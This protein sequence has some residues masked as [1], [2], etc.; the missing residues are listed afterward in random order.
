MGALHHADARNYRASRGRAQLTP[1]ARIFSRKLD[2]RSA[3]KIHRTELNLNGTRAAHL[4][5][6]GLR[7]VTPSGPKR[8]AIW[9]CA[10]CQ[11]G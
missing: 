4:L 1:R 2:L 5:Y 3:L 9:S 8:S 10:F 6:N 11:A 7:A